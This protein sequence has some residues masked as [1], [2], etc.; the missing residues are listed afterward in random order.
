MYR[1]LVMLILLPKLSPRVLDGAIGVFTSVEGVQ[2]QSETVWR[3][4]DKYSVPR[5]GFINKM[6]RMGSDFLAAV[7]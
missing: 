2:P 1:Y 6:D 7:T 3:Q 4:M 5:L